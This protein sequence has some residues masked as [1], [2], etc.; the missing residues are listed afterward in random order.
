LLQNKIIP[1]IIQVP[2]NY[3]DNRFKNDMIRL[4]DMG[5]EIHTRSVFLQGLFFMDAN[6]LPSFFNEVKDEIIN[7]QSKYKADLPAVLLRYALSFEFIDYVIIGVESEKQLLDNLRQM[8]SA[9][10][11]SEYNR[12][13]SELIL[14]PSNWPA[15]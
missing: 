2:Y 4:K 13:I 7:L 14:M 3:F 6:M 8:E 15:N 12:T 11:L 10:T 5:C 9:E 1:D